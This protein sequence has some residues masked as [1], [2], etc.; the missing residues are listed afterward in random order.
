VAHRLSQ[1]T[2]NQRLG[3]AALALGALAVFA[4]VAPG[5]T[6]RVNEKELLTAVERQQD[7]VTPGELAAWIVEGR[8]DYRLV[9]L[10]DAKDYAEYHVPGAENLPLPQVADG[11]LARNEK[12]VLYGEDAV[13]A[14][15]AWTVLKARGFVA[16]YTLLGGL[17]AWK[18]EVLFPVA[19]A[20]PTAEEQAR[21]DRAVQLARFFGG[22]PRA[23]AAPGSGPAPVAL[24][25]S[26]VQAVA[27]PT[28]PAGAGGG[29]KKRK[30]G[31]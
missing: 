1:L 23:A 9:D 8:A 20:Q 18:D 3:V 7:H 14:S 31:C 22:L 10:R 28:L 17:D 19:P 21:F 26:P 16:S 13:H 12:L 6:L 24:P 15:Q 5:R 30:E 27:A 25:V 4:D 11:G 29:P 2:L